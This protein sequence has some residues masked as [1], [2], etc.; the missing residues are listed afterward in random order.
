MEQSK[1]LAALAALANGTRLAL[2]RLLITRGDAG[3]PAGQIAGDFGMSASR[4]SFHLSALEQ[5]GLVKARRES[6]HV[7]YSVDHGAMG[8]LIAYLLQDCCRDDPKVS[9]CCTHRVTARE[10]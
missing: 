9:A 8:G 10:S 7:F 2:I 5:A 3:L 4:L 6:R 1:A